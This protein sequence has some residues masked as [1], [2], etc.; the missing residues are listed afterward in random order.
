MSLVRIQSKLNHLANEIESEWKNL[1]YDQAL[2]PDLSARHLLKFSDYQAPSLSEMSRELANMSLPVQTFNGH[3]FSD[4][5]L[6]LVRTERFCIDIYYWN[7]SDTGIHDHHFHGAFKILK[8]SSMQ[9]RYEFKT[10][11]EHGLYLSEGE[12]KQVSAKRLNHGD[13][14]SITKY[15]NFIHQ[16][17]HVEIPTITLCIRTPAITS[18]KNL[19]A[20]IYPKYKITMNDLSIN[21]SKWL[22]LLKVKLL[23]NENAS[24]EI[25]LSNEEIV[26]SIYNSIKQRYVLDPLVFQYLSEH[27]L[28]NNFATDFIETCNQS[29]KTEEKLRKLAIMTYIESLKAG[30]K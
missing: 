18:E 5:P 30:I 20:Y 3:D 28:K 17:F 4:F 9:V 21:K 12:L 19:S 27:L 29:N 7:R 13:V 10:K 16:V 8:G 14:Q 25:P 26:Y 1:A 11:V 15:D 2:F 24:E 6:T 23:A 22:Q